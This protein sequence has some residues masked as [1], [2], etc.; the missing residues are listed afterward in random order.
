VRAC[1]LQAHQVGAHGVTA[2]RSGGRTFAFFA[3]DRDA[4]GSPKQRSTLFEWVGL[5]PT[6]RFEPV[7][8]QISA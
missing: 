3:Y 7:Q 4:E 8:A 2:V 1:L 6:G 5:Y